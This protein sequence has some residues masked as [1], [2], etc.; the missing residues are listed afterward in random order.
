MASKTAE[1]LLCENCGAEYTVMYD[2]DNITDEMTY[3]P[4]CGSELDTYN[5]EDQGEL[6]FED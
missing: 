4:F 5:D 2:S 3:C 1:E 6:N